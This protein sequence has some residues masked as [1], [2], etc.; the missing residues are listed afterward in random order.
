MPKRYKENGAQV[1]D[2]IVE[3]NPE[4]KRWNY[5]ICVTSLQLPRS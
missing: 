4:S 1:V 2:D 5:V 3:Y